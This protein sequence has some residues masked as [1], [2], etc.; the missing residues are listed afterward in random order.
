[1]DKS[2]LKQLIKQV[3]KER[4]SFA[5]D[6]LIQSIREAVEDNIE[7]KPGKHRNTPYKELSSSWKQ[8]SIAYYDFKTC[9]RSVEQRSKLK[10]YKFLKGI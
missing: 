8:M 6:N 5:Y 7:F 1:M 2:N 3:F 9:S 4:A 10:I